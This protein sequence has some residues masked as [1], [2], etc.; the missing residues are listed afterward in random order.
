MHKAVDKCAQAPARNV[1]KMG[2]EKMTSH[3][4]ARIGSI[5]SGN[6]ARIGNVVC[7][8]H[9]CAARPAWAGTCCLHW[10][11]GAGDAYR[12]GADGSAVTSVRH[13]C[14]RTRSAAHTRRA[15]ARLAAA[16]SQ[17]S[18]KTLR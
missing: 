6:A 3:M 10:R 15:T 13:H 14:P 1:V 16:N 18:A 9:R 5:D 17:A 7:V 12:T 8:A 4:R 11:D 2:G